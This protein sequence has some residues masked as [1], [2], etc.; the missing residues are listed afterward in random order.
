ML[1]FL[2]QAKK[3]ASEH[4]DLVDKGLDKANEMV[5]EKTGGRFDDQTDTAQDKLEGFLGMNPRDDN[6]Q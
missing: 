4:A 1:D 3:L 2:E 6:N 5:D